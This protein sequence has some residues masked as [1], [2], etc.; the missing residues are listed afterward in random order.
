MP[1]L[2]DLTFSPQ[3][4]LTTT[5]S[6]CF[7]HL[8]LSTSLTPPS[9][10][11]LNR[12]QLVTPLSYRH[13]NLCMRIFPFLSALVLLTGKSKQGSSL[14][15]VVSMSPPMTP[16]DVLF[17]NN[18]MITSQLATLASYKPASW[19]LQNSGGQASLPLF[20]DTLKAV[21]NASRTKPTHIPPYLHY[22]L[23]SCS[24]LAHSSKSPVISSQI[25]PCPQ[26][27]I[28]SWSW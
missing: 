23:S 8:F 16:S 21:P 18:V 28:L 13:F 14:T 3:M 9:P 4:I 27:S 10:N 1:S 5:M 24:L 11:T 20:A 2:A 22:L 26:A 6:P 19:S 25:F 17:L 7:P 12:L 15:T